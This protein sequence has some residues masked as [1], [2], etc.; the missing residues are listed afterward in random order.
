MRARNWSVGRLLLVLPAIAFSCS[1]NAEENLDSLK[2]QYRRPTAI[3]FPAHAP[4]SPQLATLGKKLFF[5]PRL[6]GAKNMSCA[7]CHN[8]SFG[9]EVPV[10]RP[11]GAANE[12]VGRQAPTVLNTA[13]VAPL[14]W[15]GRAPTL[16]AQAEGPITAPGEMNMKFD[17]LLRELP[18][19]T[20]Y[21]S[22][23]ERLF[24]DGMTKDNVL[25]AIA[26]Y[27][28]TVVTEWAP[29]DR[30]VDGDEGAISA[31]AKNGFKLFN[32]KA[33]CAGCHSGWNFTDNKFHDIGIDTDDIGRAKYEL[34]NVYAKHAFKTPGLRNLTQRAPF[35]HNGKQDNLL[36]IIEHYESGGM[37]RPSLSPLMK[38]FELTDA[39][40]DNLLAFLVSLTAEKSETPVPVLPN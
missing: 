35:T 21:K 9:Y 20:E 22:W 10:D 17:D 26:T 31:S 28:R 8:P 25:T 24:P 34:D 30:W 40:R 7:S 39:E 33:M 13:W 15:D 23:F 3:P 27:E 5:D 29:F 37:Q 12:K 2:A 4:Y 1:V 32:G 19:I 18:K 36:A 38:P 16:E 14:F 11:V 6:S